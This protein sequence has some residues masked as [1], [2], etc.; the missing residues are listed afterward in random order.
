MSLVKTTLC[1]VIASLMVGC[2]SNAQPEIDHT[3]GSVLLNE[4]S[5]YEMISLRPTNIQSKT[6][7]IYIRKVNKRL[8]ETH[9][10]E[11]KHKAVPLAEAVY[12]A[13]DGVN[14]V[15]MDSYVD[16]KQEISVYV[17]GMEFS[18]YL[19][20]LG[21]KTG[22]SFELVNS[23][24]LVRS[25]VDKKFNLASLSDSQASK[26][27]VDISAGQKSSVEFESET[28]KWDEIIDLCKSI[29]A[30]DEHQGVETQ[31]PYCEG[32]KSVGLLIASGSPLN[33]NILDK[34][35]S[36][37]ETLASTMILVEVKWHDISLGRSEALKQ[38][39]IMIKNNASGL[40]RF[41]STYSLP[42]SEK[43]EA[44]LV[45]K[46]VDIGLGFHITPKVLD[47]RNIQLSIMPSVTSVTGWTDADFINA[48]NELPVVEFSNFATQ[49][50]TR[51]DKAIQIGEFS[52]AE[53]T[54]LF[55][56]GS[57]TGKGSMSEILSQDGNKMRKIVMTVTPKIITGK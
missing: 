19:E 40:A 3:N 14:L 44:S 21:A 45:Y 56:E 18:K 39:S 57:E 36:E 29:L 2:A 13:K 5:Q 37:T 47:N 33:M 43:N 42:N 51:S 4:Q 15:V 34:V 8:Q 41:G 53:V 28:T 32:V 30:V 11:M 24:V 46:D 23:D 55:V 22:Y 50:V 54:T 6:D 26:S 20:Y 7:G 1:S 10:V 9:K 12:K 16:I 17:D 49:V 38:T 31:K 48:R 25:F 35:I 27:K 52:D